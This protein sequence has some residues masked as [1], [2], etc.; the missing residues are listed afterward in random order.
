MAPIHLFRG[1]RSVSRVVDVEALRSLTASKRGQTCSID[2][3]LQYNLL[4]TLL[5][6]RQPGLA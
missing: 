3:T 4:P 6:D 1:D 5:S 2:T